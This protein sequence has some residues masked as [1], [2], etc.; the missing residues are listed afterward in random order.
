MQS[1]PRRV[2]WSVQ[3]VE[4]DGSGGQGRVSGDGSPTRDGCPTPAW[5]PLLRDGGLRP[6]LSTSPASSRLKLQALRAT[7]L[8]TATSRAVD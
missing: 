5:T 8:V 6:G 7:L 4:K 2:R 3:E 1:K